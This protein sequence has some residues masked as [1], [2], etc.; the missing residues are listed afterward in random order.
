MN[1]VPGY[2]DGVWFVAAWIGIP[3][4]VLLPIFAVWGLASAYRD[5]RSAAEG[6][7]R[8]SSEVATVW[9]RATLHPVFALSVVSVLGVIATFA[10][11][12]CIRWFDWSL[13]Q[14]GFLA[15]LPIGPDPRAGTEAP[16][17]GQIVFLSGL[18]LIAMLIPAAIFDWT[19]VGVI[20]SIPLYFAWCL[21]WP[22]A[23]IAGIVGGLTALTRATRGEQF[24][25]PDPFWLVGVCGVYLLSCW[26]MWSLLDAALKKPVAPQ[27]PHEDH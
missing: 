1:P 26:A 5:A 2:D 11:N 24:D 3:V 22:A 9:G 10:A 27:R 4:A 25:I 14:E 18:T 8:A 7:R 13:R 21:C 12:S 20:T 17:V 15:L 6:I 16:E 19:I 23:I